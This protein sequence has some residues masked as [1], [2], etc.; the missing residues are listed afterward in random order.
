[1]FRTRMP[2]CLWC[3]NVIVHK[4]KTLSMCS[5][6]EDGVPGLER[7]TWDTDDISEYFKFGIW[8]RV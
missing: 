5:A 8:G 6:G 1:M 4:A 3:Y 7:I 2:K